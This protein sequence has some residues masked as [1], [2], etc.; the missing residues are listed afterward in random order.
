MKYGNSPVSSLCRYGF[1]HRSKLERSVC[2]LIY[3]RERA[4]E[5]RHE[6][7]EDHIIICG[8]ADHEC[9]KKKEYVADFRCFNLKTNQTFWIEG[10]G[11]A[12][13]RWPITKTLWKHYGPGLLEIWVGDWRR[14][15]LLETLAKGTLV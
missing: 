15:I 14:P 9:P 11:F 4:G 1:S 8:P 6:Q 13:D 5:L 12:N 2:D 3:L 7:H 10:K